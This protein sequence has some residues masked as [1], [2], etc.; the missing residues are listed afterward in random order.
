LL[1]D[2][3]KAKLDWLKNFLSLK[4]GI[5]KHDVYRLVFAL[6]K[7][8]ELEACFMSIKS[9]TGKRGNAGR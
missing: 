4:N 7:P 9:I 8:E 1:E 2:Y 5:P 6:L 3:E